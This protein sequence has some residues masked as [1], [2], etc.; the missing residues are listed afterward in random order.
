MLEVAYVTATG[1]AHDTPADTADEGMAVADRRRR[2]ADLA[3]SVL[4][5]GEQTEITEQGDGAI[6]SRLTNAV[7]A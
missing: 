2:I 1:E 7:T 6:D 4:H 5:P 3:L